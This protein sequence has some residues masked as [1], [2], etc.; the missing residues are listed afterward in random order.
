MSANLAGG[1]PP[2]P[3]A[4]VEHLEAVWPDRFPDKIVGSDPNALAADMHRH[5][6]RL[7]VVRYLRT[8]LARQA[9][10]SP[11]NPTATAT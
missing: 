2:I 1:P 8:H 7:E 9:H 3:S 11:P 10:A 5:A 6:G 4:L